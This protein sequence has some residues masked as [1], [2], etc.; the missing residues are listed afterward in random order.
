MAE[1]VDATGTY[2]TPPS[3]LTATA[4]LPH[5]LRQSQF[6]RFVGATLTWSTGHLLVIV[7]NSFLIYDM[8]DSGLWLA[9]LGASIAVPQFIFAGVGGVLADRVSRKIMLVSGASV[10]AVTMTILAILDFAD[11]LEPWHIVASGA[12]FGAAF[13]N[14]WT[15]R[16]AFITNLVDRSQLVRAVS[17]DQT[18]FH[19]SR[20]TAPLVGG[21]LLA[22]T[23]GE[24][25]FTLGA[26]MFALAALLLLT[27]SPIQRIE[28]RQPPIWEGIS[29]AIRKIR[30][31]SVVSV[32]MLFTA[33][34]AVFLGGF[35]YLA[36]VFAT[37]VFDGGAVEQGA[38]LTGMGVGAVAGALWLGTSGSVRRA[39]LGMLVTNA[40]TVVAIGGF[41][42]STMLAASIAFAV[43]AGV[44]N[45][46]HITLGTVAIQTRVE[47]DMRGRI[48][49][50]YEMAWGFFPAG[51]LVFGALVAAIGPEPALMVG[52]IGTGVVTAIVW[53]FSAATRSYTL[54]QR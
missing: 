27:L 7:S 32:V 17:F 11:A 5:V 12:A 1:N 13:G 53:L 19:I 22:L 37:D 14:D 42:V 38:I 52:V 48:F 31:D 15:A 30:S 41:S 40:L 9:A 2:L 50:A 25:A 49:G 18:A 24:G 46:V 34:N 39:G 28:D 44:V 16:Q 8:T 23:G 4:A 29:D 47:D 35:V 43:V 6:L 33:V 51:G 3:D 21:V 20:I 10:G 26:I 36:P 45:A 54:D